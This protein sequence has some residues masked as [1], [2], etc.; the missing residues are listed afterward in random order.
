MA[1]RKTNTIKGYKSNNEG[2]KTFNRITNSVPLY[3]C[4]YD[5]EMKAILLSDEGEPMNAG[6]VTDSSHQMFAAE[7]H[8]DMIDEATKL[9]V[10][11]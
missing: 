6:Q 9:G 2:G 1:K 8:K 11:I 4:V 3:V 10:K 7:T 5:S